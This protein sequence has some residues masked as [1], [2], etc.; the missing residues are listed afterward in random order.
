MEE[1]YAHLQTI[2]V[3]AQ[4]LEATNDRELTGRK[5]SWGEKSESVIQIADRSI[6]Y[7][8]VVGVSSQYGTDYYLE[9]LVM[10][11]GHTG[12][13]T[14]KKTRMIRKKRPRIWGRAVDIEWRGDPHLSSRLDFDYDLKHMLLQLDRSALKGGI[15]IIPE[16]KHG[17]TR[18]RTSHQLPSPD[19]FKA[20]DAIAKHVK[21]WA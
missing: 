5:R 7:V 20:I 10:S 18:I 17:H 2:G 3:K 1:L 14:M 4:L 21:S 19:L 16:P 8:S 12:G 13:S 6:D 11:P 9:Y 15:S